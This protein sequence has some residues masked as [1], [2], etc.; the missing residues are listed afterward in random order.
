MS[1]EHDTVTTAATPT[2]EPAANPA[3]MTHRSHTAS[4]FVPDY[5]TGTGPR[6]KNT[7]LRIATAV[8][9]I[10]TALSLSTGLA[11]ADTQPSPSPAADQQVT[12]QAVIPVLL[13]LFG[14]GNK[15]FLCVPTGSFA[16]LV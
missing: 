3:T 8:A 1:T 16:C 9:A 15:S 12:D 6:R 13:G 11:A 2:H 5:A 7:M 10:A 4:V 14:Q